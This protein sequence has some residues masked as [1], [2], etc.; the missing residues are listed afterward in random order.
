[1]IKRTYQGVRP[2][3]GSYKPVVTHVARVDP[4]NKPE[5]LRLLGVLK[6]NF[7]SVTLWV[8]EDKDIYGD[9]ND[10]CTE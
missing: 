3:N 5:H 7:P 6:D 10:A 2:D 4:L 9:S 1:M 8:W